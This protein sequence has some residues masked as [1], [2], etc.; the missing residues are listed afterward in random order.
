MVGFSAS[1]CP[2][3]LPPLHLY[4]ELDAEE[5]SQI[6]WLELNP[7]SGS[8]L[9]LDI[10]CAAIGHSAYTFLPTIKPANQQWVK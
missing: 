4:T 9:F 10:K 2:D 6:V 7:S 1:L 8:A 5:D 3:S